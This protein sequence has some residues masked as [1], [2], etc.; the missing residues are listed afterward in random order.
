MGSAA[1][2]PWQALLLWGEMVRRVKPTTTTT[3]TAIGAVEAA[4]TSLV[5]IIVLLVEEVELREG[6]LSEFWIQFRRPA[7]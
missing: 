3:T 1:A 5:L 6:L 2:G 7:W 4:S